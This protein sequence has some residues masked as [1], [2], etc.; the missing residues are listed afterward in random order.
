MAKEEEMIEKENPKSQKDIFFGSIRE[1]HPDFEDE[2]DVYAYAN[3]KYNTMRAERNIGRNIVDV[4]EE[5]PQVLDFIQKA[6][7]FGNLSGA[8]KSIPKEEL[9]KA[10][11]EYDKNFDDEELAKELSAIR[12]QREQ[13]KALMAE[14]SA[15][16]DASKQTVE[17]F[18][19]ANGMTPEEVIA[20]VQDILQQISVGKLPQEL[21]T[22][23]YFMNNRENDLKAEYEKG[24]KE[25]KNANIESTVMKKEN[26]TDGLPNSESGLAKDSP[27]IK[28]DNIDKIIAESNRIDK[29]F[30]GI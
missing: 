7:K 13:E 9:Q 2:E 5:N 11:D 23:V 6:Q 14:I 16:N 21:L 17:E 4:L 30:R 25:G 3:N 20:S 22:A 12:S 19:S 24:V 15:N 1:K 29:F 28:E 8:L 18:A 26:T 10:I 27:K